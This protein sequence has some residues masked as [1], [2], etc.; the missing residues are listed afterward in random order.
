MIKYI[1]M[2][3]VNFFIISHIH[4]ILIKQEIEQPDCEYS[5]LVSTRH[6]VVF[7]NNHLLERIINVCKWA[8]HLPSL[9][10]FFISTIPTSTL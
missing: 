6:N 5:L 8:T 4:T 1:A 10:C 7:H 9:S 3:L 2:L